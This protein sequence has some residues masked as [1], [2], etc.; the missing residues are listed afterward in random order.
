MRT[1]ALIAKALGWPEAKIPDGACLHFRLAEARDCPTCG[2]TVAAELAPKLHVRK[3]PDFPG[4]RWDVWEGCR[5]HDG[6]TVPA[7]P[8]ALALGLAALDTATHRAVH[9]GGKLPA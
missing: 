8:A 7:W 9:N 3:D 4:W 1:P 2:P 6:G 5:W